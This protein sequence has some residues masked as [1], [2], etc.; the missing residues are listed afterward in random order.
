MGFG[1]DLDDSNSRWY[2]NNIRYIDHDQ[3]QQQ[4]W[5]SDYVLLYIQQP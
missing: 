4:T 5:Y 3:Q 1:I 2:N